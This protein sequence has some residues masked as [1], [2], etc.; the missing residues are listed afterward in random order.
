MTKEE[1]R[2][3]YRGAWMEYVLC[4]DEGRKKQLEDLMDSMQDSCVE[5]WDETLS[6]IG[7]PGR[8]IREWRVFAAT[9]P[10]YMEFWDMQDRE[11]DQLKEKLDEMVSSRLEE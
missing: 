6:S 2:G 10:G 3:I 1:A 5:P 9:L 4:H 7:I 11:F 8:A